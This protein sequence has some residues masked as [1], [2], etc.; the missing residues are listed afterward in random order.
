MET[1]RHDWGPVMQPNW[2]RVCGRCAVERRVKPGMFATPQ[3]RVGEAAPW[4]DRAP[5]RGCVIA[6]AKEET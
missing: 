5:C 4:L 6:A 2:R 1:S 3:Y